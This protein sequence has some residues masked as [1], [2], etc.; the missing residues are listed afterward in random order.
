M[1]NQELYQEKDKK[2]L[3]LHLIKES[4]VLG[5]LS[6]F[7]QTTSFKVPR[8]TNVFEVGLTVHLS[9][10]PLF[11]YQIILR[12]VGQGRIKLKIETYI[13]FYW[14]QMLKKAFSENVYKKVSKVFRDFWEFSQESI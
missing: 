6:G 12:T 9:V 2:T 11:C 10:C 13:F 8:V 5:K 7:C 4:F 3:S 14:G 1:M